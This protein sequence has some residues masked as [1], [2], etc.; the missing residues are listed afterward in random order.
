MADKEKTSKKVTTTKEVKKEVIR[1]KRG[2]ET[3]SKQTI[4]Q[5]EEFEVKKEEELKPTEKEKQCYVVI[6]PVALEDGVKIY[7]DKINRFPCKEIDKLLAQGVI[8]KEKEFVE[9]KKMEKEK[10]EAVKE[11]QEAIQK[12]QEDISQLQK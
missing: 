10:E 8:M 5:A 7:G 9:V 2:N 3:S 12:L 11:K 6:T 1:S 4:R